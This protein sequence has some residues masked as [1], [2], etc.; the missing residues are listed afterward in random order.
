MYIKT[1]IY[2]YIHIE[3]SIFG[4]I[5]IYIYIHINLLTSHYQNNGFPHSLPT[6]QGSPV[7]R[8]YGFEE[9]ALQKYPRRIFDAFQVPRISMVFLLEDLPSGK[10]LNNENHHRKT[11][12]PRKT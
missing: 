9:E 10:R 2:I 6:P 8:N 3:C 1:H 11:L 5:H 12:G 4:N 7:T